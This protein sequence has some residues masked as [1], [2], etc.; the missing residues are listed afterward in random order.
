MQGDAN[1]DQGEED[2]DEGGVAAIPPMDDPQIILPYDGDG[3]HN[4][5]GASRYF[6]CPT[7]GAGPPP[8]VAAANAGFH[9]DPFVARNSVDKLKSAGFQVAQ[10]GDSGY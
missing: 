3:P 2:Q 4:I 7:P 8:A 1:Y 5:P 9:V 6:C 10:M